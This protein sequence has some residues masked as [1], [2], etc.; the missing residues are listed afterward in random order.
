MSRRKKDG[1]LPRFSRSRKDH[2][3]QKKKTLAS[4]SARVLWRMGQY[5]FEIVLFPQVIL[6]FDVVVEKPSN[7]LTLPDFCCKGI[8]SK[9]F[10]LSQTDHVFRQDKQDFLFPVNQEF[11]LS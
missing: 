2:K 7:R 11:P 1:P 4:L 6:D 10:P 5:F 3:G 9:V 8:T